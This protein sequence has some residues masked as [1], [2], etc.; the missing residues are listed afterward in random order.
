M[1]ERERQRRGFQ[2][3]KSGIFFPELIVEALFARLEL[4]AYVHGLYWNTDGHDSTAALLLTHYLLSG[5]H[6]ISSGHEH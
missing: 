6:V 1:R 2:Q 5:K 3:H 4:R